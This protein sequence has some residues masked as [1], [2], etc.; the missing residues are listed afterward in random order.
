M[1]THTILL[2]LLFIF[3]FVKA[4][5]LEMENE[6][7][8]SAAAVIKDI[9]KKSTIQAETRKVY[10]YANGEQTNLKGP[11][12]GQKPPG[13]KTKVFAPGMVSTYGNHEFCCRF[14]PDGKEFYFN[15]GMTIMVCRWETDGWTA[16]EPVKFTGR[17]RS[18]EPHI[19]TDNK[20]LFYGTMRPQPGNEKEKN[21]Y[22]IWM[23]ERTEKGWSKP[24]YVGLGMY[25]S[26]TQEGIIYVTDVSGRD[27]KSQGIVKTKIK[28]GRFGKFERQ[29]GGVQTPAPDRFPGRHPFIAA[30]ESFIIFDAYKKP[31]GGEGALF[32]C[33]K[34]KDGSWGEAI[35]FSDNVNTG[36]NICA[37]LSPDGKYLF[38]HANKDIYWVDAK[39]IEELKSKD[40]N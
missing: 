4:T 3:T 34:K 15:R 16:P 36:H 30:D 37:S 2:L 11:Y 25:V 28:N 33:F 19:T 1:K 38:H 27:L 10:Q 26:S 23:V 24:G 32:V 5:V 20:Q 40:L 8:E 6:K 31:E 7:K 13:L 12:L 17:Y 9:I 14:S 21:P 29:F 18:H 39:I 22:G 35:K